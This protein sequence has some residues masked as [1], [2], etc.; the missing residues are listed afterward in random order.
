M[1]A[2]DG[3]SISAMAQTAPDAVEADP[4]PLV[5]SL[6]GTYLKPE[7]Q[8]LH[9]Q[10]A[11]LQRF[12]TIVFT[13]QVEN[14]DLFPFPEVV[15][16]TRIT[17]PRV[18]GNFLLRF[19]YKHV[20]RQWP[21]PRPITRQP[22]WH[23]Y[24]LPELLRQHQPALVHVYYGHKAVKYLPMLR[25]W[26]GP[27]VVSFHGVDV[28][29][30]IDREGYLTQLREVFREARLVLGRSRSLLKRL[31]EL[32]CPPAKLRLNRT[33][34]PLD[35]IEARERR[36]PPDGAWRLVQ[37][38]RLIQKK[39]LYTV[40]NALPRVI[41][42]FP[43][44]KFVLCGTG[45]EEK[46][47]GEKVHSMGLREHVL[48]PGWMSQKD[49]LDSFYYSHLFLHPSEMTA[50]GDQEGVPNSMLEAMAT[51]LPVVATRHGGIPEA[52][53]HGEDGFLVPERSPG[54]LAEAIIA[55]LADPIMLRQFSANAAR[56]VREKFDA[57]QAVAALEDCYLEA[58][59]AVAVALPAESGQ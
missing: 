50:S 49:L 41:E 53:T 31:E 38:C 11:G 2:R 45:P 46:K 56:S 27:F 20:V 22:E 43:E 10:I 39:G 57:A 19:W 54:A 1:G 13:E 47:L 42:R 59:E 14:L 21:P 16:M 3:G 15:T 25:A 34:I 40:L 36:P 30:F 33:P 28:V 6:C 29:K 7:M 55:L 58:V 26:G 23:P 24:N 9:R 48:M 44:L 51:G 35:R 5:I 4:R 52:V 12:R 8:S 37:A 18:R 17:R 32:G